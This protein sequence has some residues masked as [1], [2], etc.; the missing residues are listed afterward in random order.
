LG[1]CFAYNETIL[2]LTNIQDTAGQERFGSITPAY[3][4]GIPC[5]VLVCNGSNTNIDEEVKQL[6]HWYKEIEACND[7]DN[8]PSI[9]VAVNKMD[10]IQ[11][12]EQNEQQ[13][14]QEQQD[15]KQKLVNI[16][17]VTEA[18]IEIKQWCEAQQIKCMATSAKT[19]YNVD[20]MFKTVVEVEYKSREANNN[21]SS[22]SVITSNVEVNSSST[23]VV[24]YGPCINC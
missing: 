21:V 12:L 24:N 11:S 8:M 19:G 13:Q 23:N 22:N 10:L 2:T 5:I 14:E 18:P 20:A 1:T 6:K 17:A 16:G 4:R 3:L 9:V 7:A 15:S